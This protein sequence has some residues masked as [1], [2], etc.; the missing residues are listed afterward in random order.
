MEA[1]GST[2][3]EKRRGDLGRPVPSASKKGGTKSR[4]EG[5]PECYSTGAFVR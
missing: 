3:D 1:F 5:R 2:N 4:K